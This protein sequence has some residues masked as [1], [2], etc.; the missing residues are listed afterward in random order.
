M[1]V[2]TQIHSTQTNQVFCFF[3]FTNAV[4]CTGRSVDDY[5]KNK[6][7]TFGRFIGYFIET[8]AKLALYIYVFSFIFI[9][10]YEMYSRLNISALAGYNINKLLVQNIDL[11]PLIRGNVITSNCHSSNELSQLNNNAS[12]LQ[13]YVS[14]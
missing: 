9:H 5:E 6:A 13:A 11:W 4:C 12:Q 3:G 10:E 8:V 2:I 14:I 7:N 1:H